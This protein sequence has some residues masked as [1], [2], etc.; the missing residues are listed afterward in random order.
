MPQVIKQLLNSEKAVT[1]GLL[2]IC[3]TVLAGM[4][5]INWVEWQDYTMKLAGLY[6]FGKTIQGA[7]DTLSRRTVDVNRTERKSV[8]VDSTTTNEET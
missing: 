3:A 2:I 1:I 7:A 5:L 8:K 4:R 6:I